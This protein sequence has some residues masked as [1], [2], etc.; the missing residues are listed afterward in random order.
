MEEASI[1]GNRIGIL[2]EGDMKCI[3]SPL[4]LMENFG[5]TINL[6]ITKKPEADDEEIINFVN[7]YIN[8][9]IN[10]EYE[11]LNE[12]IL[13]R[14]PK[15]D[16]LL[17]MLKKNS[18][19]SELDKQRNKLNIK[20]YSISMST[21]EDVFLNLSKIIKHKDKNKEESNEEEIEQQNRLDTNNSL[22]YD[23]SNYNTNYNNCTKILRDIKISFKKRIF[24][25]YRDKKMFISEILCPIL[26][27]LIGCLVGSIE[28]LEKNRVFPL[29]L[30]QLTNDTQ[31]IFYSYPDN[32]KYN[33]PNLD[34]KLFSGD[35]AN[36][37]FKR[38]EI[39]DN[40]FDRNSI[41]YIDRKSVV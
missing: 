39:S 28:F 29:H 35:L 38:I 30:N 32:F 7:K 27:T 12:E 40:N 8:Q 6:N 17:K 24:Q 36:V 20:N 15:D 11:I 26:L 13:F 5:K 41:L 22:L 25:I 3:G 18:F 14:I 16:A 31:T 2:S 10:I 34:N 19:F 23:E 37:K 33:F 21:L 1:L 4:F 9:N